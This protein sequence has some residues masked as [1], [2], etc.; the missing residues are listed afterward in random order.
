MTTAA[1][2]PLNDGFMLECAGHAGYGE[3]GKDIVCAGISALCMALEAAVEELA[4][5]GCAAEVRKHASDGYFSLEAHYVPRDIFSRERLNAVF[6]TVSAGLA[7][8]EQLHPEHV[9]LNADE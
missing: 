5:E 8:I 1:V 7:A 9:Q 3:I 6:R 2:V 4:D